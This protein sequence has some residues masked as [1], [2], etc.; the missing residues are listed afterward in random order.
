MAVGF[1]PSRL[2]A[3]QFWPSR[4]S[5][6]AVPGESLRIERVIAVARLLLTAIAFVA[7]DFNPV[8]PPSYAPVAYI[9]LILFAA[10]SIS[11]LLVLRTRQRTTPAFALTTHSI[12]LVA[13]A[14][15]LPM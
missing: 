1:A 13:A 9:L 5:A 15:T 2:Q 3:W 14:V 8:E 7:I 10:H 11:A 4:L 6:R 12:D